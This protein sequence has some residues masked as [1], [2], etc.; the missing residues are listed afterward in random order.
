MDWMQLLAIDLDKNWID[1]EIGTGRWNDW[2][3]VKLIK[4]NT[5]F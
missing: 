3:I 5:Q 4:T 1:L 2:K